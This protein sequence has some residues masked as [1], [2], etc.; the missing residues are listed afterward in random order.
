MYRK[1]KFAPGEYYHLYN[2][3]NNKSTIS[4]TKR[5]KERFVA[6]LFLANGDVPFHFKDIQS[7]HV[8]TYP[9]GKTLVD[10]G[11]YCLMPNHF[12]LL[13]R[14]KRG[15]GAS[16]FMQKLATA[17]AMYFNT[18]HQRTGSLFEGTFRSSH[19]DNDR[20]LRYLFAYIHLNPLKLMSPSWKERFPNTS[21]A[22][23]FLSEYTG[24]SYSDYLGTPR[25]EGV[26]INRRAFPGF[27]NRT[28]DFKAFVND[29]ITLRSEHD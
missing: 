14:E 15:G 19:A 7:K 24:S 6:L 1:V 26:I 9:R 18:V 22:E 16:L 11:A 12:H 25:P 28:A 20:Y 27:F 21:V 8:F 4:V 10:I 29:W 2:R 13:I 3:G 17:Y 23:K 5:D